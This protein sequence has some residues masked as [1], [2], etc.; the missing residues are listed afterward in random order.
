MQIYKYKQSGIISIY[1]SDLSSNC[2][3]L[4]SLWLTK[5]KDY[6][7]SKKPPPSV[8]VYYGLHI[9]FHAVYVFLGT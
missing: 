5:T 3:E 9:P 1:Q 2:C 7:V 4:I 8:S 6:K